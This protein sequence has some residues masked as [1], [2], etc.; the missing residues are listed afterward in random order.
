MASQFCP[1]GGEAANEFAFQLVG[2]VVS[3]ARA[4]LFSARP[5]GGEDFI[6]KLG[7][8]G[9]GLEALREEWEKAIVL[10]TEVKEA[11]GIPRFSAHLDGLVFQP[12]GEIV[13][14]A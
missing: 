13:D 3:H 7:E 11:F 12:A 8:G 4:P 10:E 5:E 2:H 14:V 1:E 6:H 9:D